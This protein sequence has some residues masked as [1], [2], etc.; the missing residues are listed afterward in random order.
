MQALRSLF[1]AEEGVALA[2][3]ALVLGLIAIGS[4]IALAGVAVACSATWSNSS[5]AMQTYSTGSPPP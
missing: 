4:M 2:E 1:W 3:Y 5:S